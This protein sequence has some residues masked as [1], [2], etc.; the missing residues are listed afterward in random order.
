MSRSMSDMTTSI[1]SEGRRLA[2][3]RRSNAATRHA[4]RRS[5][6]RRARK[7]D[8]RLAIAESLGVA[9]RYA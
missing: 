7:T 6:R 2:E 3:L 1:Q 8:R 9:P 4:D 5:R